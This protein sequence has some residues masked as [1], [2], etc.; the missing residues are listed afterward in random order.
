MKKFMIILSLIGFIM[1][2][3][4]CNDELAEISSLGIVTKIELC[5]DW[6]LPTSL[7]ISTTKCS[8]RIKGTRGPSVGMEVFKT[9]KTWGGDRAVWGNGSYS[10]SILG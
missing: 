4:S 5:K 2:G 8:F 10:S 7:F 6:L 9:Y 3:I 1:I